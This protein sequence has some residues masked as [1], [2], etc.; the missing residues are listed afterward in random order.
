MLGN[1]ARPL[2]GNSPESLVSSHVSGFW[3]PLKS[4]KSP[5]G[6]KTPSPRGSKRY[7]ATGGVGLGIIASLEKST[8][9]SIPS[10]RNAIAVNHG[11]NNG[12]FK[13]GFEGLEMEDYTIVITHH[14]PGKS[15]TKMYFHEQQLQ[16]QQRRRRSNH[17]SLGHDRNGF[18]GA[19]KETS[20]T[21]RFVE[22]DEYPTSDFLSSCHL[23]KKK[24]HGK[25]IFMYRGEKA[26]CS[27]ECRSTQI[28]VDERKEQCKSAKNSRLGYDNSS[29]GQI[30]WTE[31]FAI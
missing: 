20:S 17:V 19:I 24:L 10:P 2:I 1:R 13:G 14:G 3:D 7:D 31:I 22:D 16:E 5:L 29:S 21:A 12:V 23:C 28:M 30:L 18:L 25:D 8:R 11:N 26:F 15:S 27:S 9:R 4:P 6:L